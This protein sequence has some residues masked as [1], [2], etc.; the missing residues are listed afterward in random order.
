MTVSPDAR[1]PSASVHA[2][3]GSTPPGAT[4]QPFAV[5]TAAAAVAEL[6][7]TFQPLGPVA[8]AVAAGLSAR[9]AAAT[10]PDADVIEFAGRVKALAERESRAV[11]RIGTIEDRIRFKGPRHPMNDDPRPGA[12]GQVREMALVDL[13]AMLA[14]RTILAGEL[15]HDVPAEWVADVEQSIAR[16][17]A[18]EAAVQ[19]MR[20]RLGLA[21]IEKRCR[22][23]F[24]RLVRWATRLSAME[25]QTQ[26]G[27]KAKA[28]AQLAVDR[29]GNFD[30]WTQD[31]AASVGRD[32]IRIIEAE[33]DARCR[34]AHERD[35]ELLALIAQ[36]G[37]ALAELEQSDEMWA[38]FKDIYDAAKP[39]R[40]TTLYWRGLDRTPFPTLREK[41]PGRE[42]YRLLYEQEDID[43]MR[44]KAEPSMM[45]STGPATSLEGSGLA[46]RPDTAAIAREDEIL[47]AWD[48]WQAEK[49]TVRDSSGL[50]AIDDLIE[51]QSE[52]FDAIVD[53]ILDYQPG[54]FE[55]LQAKARWIASTPNAKG[56]A[57]HLMR[58]LCRMPPVALAPPAQVTPSREVV[59]TY[60]TFLL[61][62]L[63]YLDHEV[64]GDPDGARRG[65]Y[66]DNPAASFHHDA[67]PPS[68]RAIAVLSTVG[69]MPGAS[70]EEKREAEVRAG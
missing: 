36:Y 46:W 49:A 5:A 70:A 10:H 4:V 55:G 45:M 8:N 54:T 29:A 38:G 52:V 62:E 50:T 17:E 27:L 16:M 59:E 67:P 22:R 37:P 9:R 6:P 60:R 65:Y 24:S 20:D 15:P 28:E 12:T 21:R 42:S 53:K 18:Y 35:G 56:Y 2:L 41:V 68:T 31:L 14:R 66:M 51:T 25:P 30:T 57:K 39:P 7:D 44:A 32:A 33:A 26:A 69:L 48:S 13:R 34:D 63:R 58:D 19:A 40:P 64:Y 61:F 23:M 43:A 3:S 11:V 47:A 1:T